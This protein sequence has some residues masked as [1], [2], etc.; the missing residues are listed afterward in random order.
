MF[1]DNNENT[2]KIIGVLELEWGKTDTHVEPRPYHALSYRLKGGGK[3]TDAYHSQTTKDGDILFMPAHTAYR[4]CAEHEK[5]I[6]IHFKSTQDIHK[7]F[8]LSSPPSPLKFEE[9]FNF[10]HKAWTEKKPG[11]YLKTMSLFY[12]ILE[13]LTRQLNPSFSTNSYLSIKPAI[14]YMHL[15]FGDPQ[16]KISDLFQMVALSDTQ[17]RKNFFDVFETT[18]L[19]YLNELRIEYAC[20]LLDGSF[21]SIDEIA[22][23][24]GFNDSKHFSTVFKEYKGYSPLKFRKR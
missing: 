6:V 1:F 8:E 3:I 12:K 22:Y 20:E 10:A 7:S 19:K 18:P 15:H 23:K 5:I 24:S 16:L 17:F 9:I 2:F 14:D 4:L 11:Y 13:Q 21:M